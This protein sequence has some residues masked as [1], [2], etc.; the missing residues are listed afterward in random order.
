MTRVGIQNVPNSDEFSGGGDFTHRRHV[1]MPEQGMF[2]ERPGVVQN[3]KVLG[4]HTVLGREFEPL[5]N[6]LSLGRLAI[7]WI[8]LGIA[9][10]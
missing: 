5:Q 3:G 6:A 8:Y 2:N 4:V 9:L 1:V 10:P 7:F